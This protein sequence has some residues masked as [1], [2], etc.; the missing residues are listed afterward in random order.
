MHPIRTPIEQLSID[1]IG[2]IIHE[3]NNSPEVITR[4]QP[5]ADAKKK[6]ADLDAQIRDRQKAIDDV[7]AEEARLRQNISAL[8]GTTEEKPLAKHYGDAMLIQEEKLTTLRNQQDTDRQQ[9]ATTQKFLNDQI[10]SLNADLKF[11][12]A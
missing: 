12:V 7:N 8:K 2:G 6:L 11:P 10:Q 4:L 1:N 9:R 3:S 5:I